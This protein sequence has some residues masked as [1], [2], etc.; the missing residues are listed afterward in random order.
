[1]HAHPHLF[2]QAQLVVL[3]QDHGL[4]A[5]HHG[6]A[7]GSGGLL[8]WHALGQG[9]LGFGLGSRREGMALRSR[10]HRGAA[11]DS[12]QPEKWRTAKIT[13]INPVPPKHN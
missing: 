5:G 3:V 2:L 4:L 6:S 1:M 12:R 13:N 7:V 8:C 10:T 11:A 9:Q